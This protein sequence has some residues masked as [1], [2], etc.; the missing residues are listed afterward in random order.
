MQVIV[1]IHATILLQTVL[2]DTKLI[3]QL[4][5]KMEERSL[6]FIMSATKHY[7]VSHYFII[8]LTLSGFLNARFPRNM[9]INTQS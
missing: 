7:F 3:L 6:S 9:N 1:Q 2:I 8:N 4:T 5:K